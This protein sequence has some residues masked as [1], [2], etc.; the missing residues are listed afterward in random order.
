M[1]R[2]HKTVFR[3]GHIAPDLDDVTRLRPCLFTTH[4]LHIFKPVAVKLCSC[5]PATDYSAALASLT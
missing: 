1:N 4:G 2:R 3:N 5:S